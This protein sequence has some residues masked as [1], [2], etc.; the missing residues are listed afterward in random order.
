[1]KH[2]LLS[3]FAVLFCI[4][5]YGQIAAISGPGN[6]CV[7]TPVTYTDATPGGTWSSSP[8][9]VL[10][11]G[12]ATG[13]AMGHSMGLATI[14]YTVGASNVIFPVT[15]TVIPSPLVGPASVCSGSSATFY[16]TPSGGT[17]T[18]TYPAIAT[19][20]SSTGVVTGVSAGIAAITYHISPACALNT[21]VTVN[22]L[23]SLITVAGGGNYCSGG[24]GVGVSLMGSQLGISYQL[25]VGGVPVGSAIAGTGAAISFGLQTTPGVYTAVATDVTTGCS[26]TMTGSVAI[27]VNPVP[28]ITGPAAVCVGF[29]VTETASIPGGAW[30]SSAPAFASIVGA[31]STGTVTGHIPGYAVITYSI[32]A[33]GC[34]NSVTVNVN[35]NPTCTMAPGICVLDCITA[36]ASPAGGMWS[37]GAPSVATVGSLSGTVCGIS[38]GATYITYSLGTGC[39]YTQTINVSPAPAPITGPSSVCVGATI[40]VSDPTPGGIWTVDPASAGIISITGTGLVYGISAGVA[41]ISYIG[42]GG[43]GCGISKIITVNPLPAPISG[44]LAVCQGSTTP[45]S[46]SPSGGTWTSSNPAVAAVSPGGIVTGAL[47]LSSIP[48]FSTITYSLPGTGC[49]STAVVTVEPLPSAIMGTVRVCQGA[50]TTLTSTPAG[51]TWSTGSSMFTVSSTGVVTGV[52]AGISSVTYSLSTGCGRITNVTVNTSPSPI[53]G[54]PR[55][56]VGYATTLSNATPGGTW[57]NSAPSLATIGSSTGTTTVVTGIAPG[58]ALISYSLPATGCRSV[59]P[60]SV[61]PIPT[62]AGSSGVCTGDTVMLNA[63]PSGGIWTSTSSAATVGSASGIVTGLTTGIA[64]ISYTAGTGCANTT[65]ITVN[66]PPAPITGLHNLCALYDTM[67]IGDVD[68]GGIF[69][70][71]SVTIMNLP[72][73]TGFVNTHA[74]GIASINYTLP[75]GCRVTSTITVYPTPSAIIGPL[76]ACV[77][78]PVTISDTTSGGTWSSS[79]PA[80]G[81]IDPVTGSFYGLAAGITNISYTITGGCFASL[82]DTVDYVAPISGASSVCAGSVITLTASASTTGTWSSSNPAVGSIDASGN[83]T[84]I[85]SGTTDISYVIPSGCFA[86]STETVSPTTTPSVSITASAGTTLCSPTIDTFTAVVTSAGSAPVIQWFVNAVTVGISPGYSYIPASGDLVLVKVTSSD[87]CASPALVTAIDS[88]IIDTAFITASSAT[89]CGGVVTLAASGGI[90]Y[91]WSPSGLSCS[92]CGSATITPSA[93]ATY[94]VTGTD[95]A[96]CTG[97]ATVAVDGN[98]ISG[99]IIYTGGSSTDIFQVW[100]IQFNPSDSSIVATDS[101][102]TCMT[103]GTTPNYQFMDPAAGNYLVKAEL[104]GSV[105]GTSGYIPTY[106]ASTPNW[107]SAAGITHST[108]A[109][110]MNITM[111]YGTVPPG[112]GFISG[113]VYAGAG[114]GTT[115]DAPEPGMTIYL[116]DAISG[117]VLTHVQTDVTGYYSF[118]SLGFGTYIIYPESYKYYTTPSDVITLDATTPTVGSVNF[119][120]HTTSGTI[121]PA[122]SRIPA[123]QMEQ[124]HIAPNPTS[125]E[126]VITW[127]SVTSGN[128]VV[129]VND[130]TGRTVYSNEFNAATGKANVELHL[131]NGI[132]FIAVKT[133]N[134]NSG[135]KLVIQK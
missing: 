83:V 20:G 32:T 119:K 77:G 102:T 122:P 14:T 129:T 95:A 106:A 4:T 108:S 52:S 82:A 5:S 63:Y 105:P 127:P 87:P 107:Y 19:V 43:A 111:V 126:I 50:T 9:S 26:R 27:V 54:S 30:S 103:G 58:V 44:V 59:V 62:I 79:S 130:L 98:S 40:P 84:G 38:V 6:I 112:P 92:T 64:T 115:G 117:D 80:I 65:F 56:C 46:A 88:I 18:S 85:S 57:S 10:T 69:S 131:E 45:L 91:A 13:I 29:T 124:Y 51:G 114:K 70:S 78:T 110:A 37:S 3:F 74:P 25:Y 101:M 113:Y 53:L 132:Y 28:V 61:E 128:A 47:T 33:T 68:T 49:I 35:A 22:T 31:G 17:W 121:T 39:A 48:A 8:T 21:V 73:G 93:S 41:T 123:P 97:T 118:G 72:H 89:A 7:A 67:T 55:V 24:A 12:S 75:T 125:G 100:L 71:S 116:K 34:M 94:T 120:K 2:I 135:T 16:A 60:V 42:S 90:S 23:P 133:I 96:G 76:S 134:Y 109:D 11:I 1:M 99:T 15:V 86:T 36:S 104:V 66:A 81:T